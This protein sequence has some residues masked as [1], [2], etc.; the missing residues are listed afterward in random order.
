MF[1]NPNEQLLHNQ[2][3]PLHTDI[4]SSWDTINSYGVF[5]NY[6]AIVRQKAVYLTHGMYLGETLAW[7]LICY[8]EEEIEIGSSSQSHP[9]TTFLK[10]TLP[11]LFLLEG[12][13]KR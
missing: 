11:L 1:K 9:V 8:S 6:I 2:G 4:R 12:R 5:T 7:L 3:S 13:K 10:S